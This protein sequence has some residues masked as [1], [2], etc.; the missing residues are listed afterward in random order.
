MH[1]SLSIDK[2]I[3]SQMGLY[4]KSL[5]VSN[6]APITMNKHSVKQNT[7]FKMVLN[8]SNLVWYNASGRE[9]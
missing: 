2:V 3:V 5:P 7:C 9:A 4:M 8:A 1:I 6:L